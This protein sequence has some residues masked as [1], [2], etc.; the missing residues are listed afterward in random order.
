MKLKKII[1][2]A[3]V[4][5]M[6]LGTS[7]AQ[8]SFTDVKQDS[9]ASASIER[10]NDLNIMTGFQ[11]ATFKPANEVSKLETIVAIYNTLKAK[12][13][14]DVK[15]ENSLVEKHKADIESLK[16]PNSIKP[17]GNTYPAVA[18]ALENKIIVK[19][20]LK[21]FIKDDKLTVAKRIDTSVFMAKALN[22]FKKEKLNIIIEFEYKD[23]FDINSHL[24]KYV[25]LLIDNKIL[26]EK[27]DSEG[28][29]LPN[30][31]TTRETL[32]V[33]TN[34]FYNALSVKDFN[35]S[36]TVTKESND[37]NTEKKEDKKDKK[38]DKN[39]SVDS[40]NDN[41]PV[42]MYNE[43]GTFRGAI[44]RVYKDDKLIEV[45]DK[46]S[47]SKI[48]DAGKSQIIMNEKPLSFLNLEAGQEVKLEVVDGKLIKVFIEKDFERYVGGL[49]KL[50][51]S[52][53][54]KSGT[55]RVVVIKLEDGTEEYFKAYEG[56][57]ILKADKDVE[58]TEIT[59]GE[60]MVI[61]AEG[62]IAKRITILPKIREIGGELLKDTDFKV[63]SDLKIKLDNGNSINK[64]ID[65]K[66]KVISRGVKPIVAGSLVKV[67]MQYDEIAAIE[68]SG[69]MS[70]D[71]GTLVEIVIS[72]H[73]Q[74][75]IRDEYGE[76][77]Q[78]TI[79]DK[80]DIDSDKDKDIYSLRLNQ[81][82]ELRMDAFGVKKLSILK[83]VKRESEKVS[84]N[85]KILDVFK[86]T[87]NLKVKD[88]SNKV[89]TIGIKNDSDINI[90]DYKVND[91]VYISGT[92]LSGEFFEADLIVAF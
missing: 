78:Y 60:R 64:V 16:I 56:I 57:K 29:F 68:G 62:D 17:Y 44:I 26:D 63:G 46:N 15:S 87:N 8:R 40:S 6:M 2:L 38:D 48:Y 41:V 85:G 7:F 18:Y 9:W 33:L 31:P 39:D 76:L 84:F 20:E 36:K 22:N 88:G 28:K 42:S 90:N 25:R 35:S 69:I 11:D 75:T 59:Q 79:S 19:D 13:M 66:I 65:K 32:A 58:L 61:D 86:T 55:Y 47:K 23:S 52:F 43:T 30:F 10:V 80:F 37:S 83:E 5:L 27:G 92:A 67:I 53:N 3:L 24:A 89:W 21:S 50:S 72:E 54:A 77:K 81:K 12:N 70:K 34:N 49:D 74:I 45:Q 91:N 4:G 1:S 71:V 14:V 73:P 51:R 82:L